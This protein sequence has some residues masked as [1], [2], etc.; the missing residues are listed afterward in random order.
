MRPE[1]RED[2]LYAE[3]K[4]NRI[5]LE[6]EL[7]FSLLPAPASGGTPELLDIGCGVGSI[8]LALAERGYHV[9]GLDFSPVA[10]EKAVERGVEAV[11]SD[12]DSDGLQ[13]GDGE[14]DVVWAGD[15]LEHVFDP[16]SLVGEMA[17]VLKDDGRVLISIPNNFSLFTRS[18]IFL[19]GTSI[20]SRI[21]RDL[22]LCKHHTFFSWELFSYMAQHN[23]LRVDAVRALC[24]APGLAKPWV[25]RSAK[26][27]A[28]FGREF[29]VCCAKV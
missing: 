13:F 25:V 6:E 20:Q 28:W 15:V 1:E 5:E 23:G 10:V 16:V 19:F 3:G 22:G 12:V 26:F 27:G 18:R 11:C 4:E 9:R 29:I 8:S 2:Q 17:R 7:M 21:Y 24:R 14:F